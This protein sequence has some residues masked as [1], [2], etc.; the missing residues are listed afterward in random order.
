MPGDLVIVGPSQ[1]G[2]AGELGTVVAD[3][4]FG[5]AALSEQLIEFTGNTNARDR[6][7]KSSG[8]CG[9]GIGVRVPTARLRPPR[10]RTVRRSSR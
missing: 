5:L 10:R 3:D 2:V 9:I 7:I 6:C 1:D 8:H 4:C